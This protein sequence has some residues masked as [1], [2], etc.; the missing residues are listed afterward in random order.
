MR[1]TLLYNVVWMTLPDVTSRRAAQY[2]RSL[3]LGVVTYE[4]L[5]VMVDNLA[6][7]YPDL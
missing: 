6:I 2:T 5:A 1:V 3:A 4:V 7:L